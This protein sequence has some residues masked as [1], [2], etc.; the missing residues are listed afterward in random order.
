MSKNKVAFIISHPIQYYVPILSG[1][2]ERGNIDL[3]VFY[4]W[5]KESISKFDP[6]FHRVS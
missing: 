1:L 4:T 2:T 5:G 6:G 3:K